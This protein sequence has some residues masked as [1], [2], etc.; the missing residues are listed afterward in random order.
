MIVATFRD[1]GFTGG[2]ARRGATT[3]DDSETEP[4][5]D[6]VVE[7]V[8]KPSKAVGWGYMGSHNFT[9]SAWGTLSGTSFNPVLNVGTSVTRLFC[10][11]KILLWTGVE[12]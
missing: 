8:P 7:V 10:I 2:S 12:L 6:D 5:D 3:E 1:T 4:D 11:V 9:P